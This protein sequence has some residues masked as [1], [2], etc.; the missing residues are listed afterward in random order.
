M[1]AFAANAYMGHRRGKNLCADC[2][3]LPH[4]PKSTLCAKCKEKKDRTMK[5]K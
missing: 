1:H 2:K 3:K 4:L 5:H